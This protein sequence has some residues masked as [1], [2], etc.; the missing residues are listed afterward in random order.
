MAFLAQTDKERIAQ[1]IADVERRTR[2]ELVTVIARAADDYL[3]IPVLWAALLALCIPG[4][5]LLSGS[6]LAAIYL[7]EA[8][9]IGF[10]LLAILFNFTPLKMRLIP[11]AVQHA[12][13]RRLAHE[14]FFAHHLHHT[15]QRTGVLIFV[16][17]AERYV[18]IIADQGI[19][20][21]VPAGAWDQ[22][23]AD[24]TSHVKRGRVVEGFLSAIDAC[25]KPLIHHFPIGPG[26]KNEL[27]NHLI[28]L[29]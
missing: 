7:Y 1:A 27:P 23:V 14:Q 19:N 6:D 29:P 26:D 2:G 25:G 12:R 24:F 11:K 13:A 8:Q 17:V 21:V 16:S 5:V 28:E 20:D 3:F 22:A 10:L 15:A 18:E 9:V 4:L